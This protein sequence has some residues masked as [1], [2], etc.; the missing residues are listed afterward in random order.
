MTGTPKSE[1][2]GHLALNKKHVK[3]DDLS[4]KGTTRIA[5]HEHLII[6]VSI[7]RLLTG[8][9]REPEPPN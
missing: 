2:I 7:T 4:P 3:V 6:P 1:E 5:A 9:Y 8:A